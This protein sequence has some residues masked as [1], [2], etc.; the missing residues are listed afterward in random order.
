[1]FVHALPDAMKVNFF[2]LHN[3]N[4]GILCLAFIKSQHMTLY[5]KCLHSKCLHIVHDMTICKR[6]GHNFL[7]NPC[8]YNVVSHINKLQ[9]LHHHH[10]NKNNA[11]LTD[12]HYY[13]IKCCVYTHCTSYPYYPLHR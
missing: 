1:M 8:S 12:T 13:I 5:S 6:I 9:Q 3:L 11:N 2:D 7:G 10:I 4:S